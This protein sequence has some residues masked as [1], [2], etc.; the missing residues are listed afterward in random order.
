MHGYGLPRSDLVLSSSLKKLGLNQQPF[1]SRQ[2]KD[3]TVTRPPSLQSLPLTSIDNGQHV[4]WQTS[5][6]DHGVVGPPLL[7]GELELSLVQ[8]GMPEPLVLVSRD[9]GQD[10]SLLRPKLFHR[11]RRAFIPDETGAAQE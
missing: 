11:R 10:Q 2:G 9:L 3:A 5:E 1:V 6:P 8:F 4:W 7:E